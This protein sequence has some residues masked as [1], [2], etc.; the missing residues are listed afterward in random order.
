MQLFR[1][2]RKRKEIMSTFQTEMKSWKVKSEKWKVKNY[3]AEWDEKGQKL[4]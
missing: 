3:H 2:F 4:L 1:D